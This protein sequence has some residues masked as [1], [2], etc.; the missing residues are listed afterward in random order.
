MSSIKLRKHGFPDCE[1]TEEMLLDYLRE[2]QD[3]RLLPH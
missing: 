1:E 2:M 3:K